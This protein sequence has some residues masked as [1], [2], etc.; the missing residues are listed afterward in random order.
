M[1]WDL[2]SKEMSGQAILR[3]IKMG[4]IPIAMDWFLPWWTKQS[5]VPYAH[6]QLFSWRP[7]PR[8]LPFSN[9]S[10]AK[11]TRRVVWDPPSD[12][13]PIRNEW[14]IDYQ[15]FVLS[16]GPLSLESGH[17]WNCRYID[18]DERE[19]ERGRKSS[20]DWTIPWPMVDGPKNQ[21]SKTKEWGP[22]LPLLPIWQ[23][24]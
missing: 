2:L 21:Q 22:A 6:T 19:R 1:A 13:P 15:P 23:R 10:M 12:K 16:Q 8:S 9:G 14:R 24:R 18:G 5:F 17:R 11:G 7:V 20:Y 3:S 4:V